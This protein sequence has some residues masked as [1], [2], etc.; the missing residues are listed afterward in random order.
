MKECKNKVSIIHFGIN[1]V[2]EFGN[3]QFSVVIFCTFELVCFMFL[4]IFPRVIETK[5]PQL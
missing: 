5:R 4:L 3:P 1:S 2:S